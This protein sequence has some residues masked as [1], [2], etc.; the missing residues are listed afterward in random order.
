MKSHEQ[1]DASL[2]PPGQITRPKK[3][4]IDKNNGLEDQFTRGRK[5]IEKYE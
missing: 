3:L 4:N 1:L 5:Y 2:S